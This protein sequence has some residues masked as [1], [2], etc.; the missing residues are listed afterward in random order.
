MKSNN[1]FSMMRWTTTFL[2]LNAPRDL[3]QLQD[4]EMFVFYF[5]RMEQ[6]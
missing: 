2:A 1:S 6:Y 4:S 5:V 3:Q